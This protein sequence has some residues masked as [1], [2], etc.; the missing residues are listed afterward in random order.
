MRNRTMMF[1]PIHLHRHTFAVAGARMGVR[2]HT[3][4]AFPMR[5]LSVDLEA[6]NPGAWLVHSHNIYHAE[7]GMVNVM[8]YLA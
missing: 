5:S 6:D 7:L 8:S 4:N 2:K 1:H 3:V